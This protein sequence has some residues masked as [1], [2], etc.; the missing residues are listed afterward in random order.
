MISFYL[1]Q[2]ILPYLITALII[3][4]FSSVQSF[5]SKGLNGIHIENPTSLDFGSNGKL[6]VSKQDVNLIIYIVARKYA[7][8]GQGTYTIADTKVKVLHLNI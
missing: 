4:S 8:E 7:D 3:T 5:N 2:S 6:Y 1:Q